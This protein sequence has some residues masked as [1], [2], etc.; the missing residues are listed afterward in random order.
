MEDIMNFNTKL[1]FFILMGLTFIPAQAMQQEKLQKEKQIFREETLITLNNI[2][3]DLE[4][5]FKEPNL[6]NISRAREQL[7]FY[8]SLEDIDTE[9]VNLI[10][11][12]NSTLS[13]QI[14]FLEQA[15]V[16]TLWKLSEEERKY[17]P[18]LDPE[19]VK[20]FENEK[21]TL[22]QLIDDMKKEHEKEITDL[23]YK[24]FDKL[25]QEDN[26]IP[27]LFKEIYKKNSSVKTKRN[28]TS[29]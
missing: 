11:N 22:S 23:Y 25:K 8:L 28:E 16:E 14:T 2:K 19:L 10:M 17:Q 29:S 6:D 13:K 24:E 18:T 5:T 12:L 20:G 9:I 7:E 27:E 26:K 1:I 15:F 3:N 4:T 21:E